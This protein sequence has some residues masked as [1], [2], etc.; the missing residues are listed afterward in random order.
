MTQAAIDYKIDL[1]WFHSYYGAPG[2]YASFDLSNIGVPQ[3][4]WNFTPAFDISLQSNSWPIFNNLIEFI[5]ETK[6]KL[7]NDT[8]RIELSNIQNNSVRKDRNIENHIGTIKK[9]VFDPISN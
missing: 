1:V 8:E 4:F 3:L 6:K 2:G 9:I 5:L 7:M